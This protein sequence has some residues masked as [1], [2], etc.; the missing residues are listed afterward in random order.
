MP[1]FCHDSLPS[2]MIEDESLK[3]FIEFS[4]PEYELPTADTIGNYIKKLF[5]KEKERV[6][7][8]LK[9]AEFVSLTTD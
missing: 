2:Y 6:K 7:A 3:G 1:G 9:G 4:C 8:E 5:E